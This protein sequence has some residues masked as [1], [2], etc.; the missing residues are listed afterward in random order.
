MHFG[1][2]P[3]TALGSAAGTC[4]SVGGEGSK[5]AGRCGTGRS[6]VPDALSTPASGWEGSGPPAGAVGAG[7]QTEV[8]HTSGHAAN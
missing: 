7:K 8:R 6:D 5:D 3:L 1:W 2:P 4:G